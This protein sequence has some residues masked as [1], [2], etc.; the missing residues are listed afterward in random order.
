MTEI[1]PSILDCPFG[2][3]TLALRLLTQDTQGV[4]DDQLRE[5]FRQGLVGALLLGEYDKLV[6]ETPADGEEDNDLA[7]ITSRWQPQIK[8]ATV[9][10]ATDEFTLMASAPFVELTVRWK[11]C[12]ARYGLHLAI[13]L[14]AGSVEDA[15]CY[16]EEAVAEAVARLTLA[17]LDD[18]DLRSLRG[19]LPTSDYDAVTDAWEFMRA[20]LPNTEEDTVLRDAWDAH[21]RQAIAH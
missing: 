14:L 12:N 10:Y 15:S 13:L 16:N 5:L 17:G 6:K 19:V 11:R 21:E 8:A 18:G 3:L 1:H 4:T 2:R 7:G 20:A 9:L